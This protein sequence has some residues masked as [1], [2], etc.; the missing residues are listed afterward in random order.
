MGGIRSSNLGNGWDAEGEEGGQEEACV[1]G[2]ANSLGGGVFSGGGSCW[3][4]RRKR[5]RQ[6]CTRGVVS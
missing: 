3:R 1:S 6:W 2:L 4:R 5:G